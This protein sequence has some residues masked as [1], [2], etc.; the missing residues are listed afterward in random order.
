[1]KFDRNHTNSE[2]PYWKVWY[3]YL[4]ADDKK[5]AHEVIENLSVRYRIVLN[6]ASAFMIYLVEYSLIFH[7]HIQLKQILI[8]LVLIP[9]LLYTA[10]YLAA[11]LA[12]IRAKLYSEK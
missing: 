3:N 4:G 7:K 2:S 8:L 10:F 6:L 1:L 12:E 11:G 5:I 9:F